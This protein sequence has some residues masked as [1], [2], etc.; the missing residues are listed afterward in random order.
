MG[1]ALQ[2]DIGHGDLGVEFEALGLGQDGAVLGDQGVAGEDDVGA[3]LVWPGPG[4][5][6]GRQAAR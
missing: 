2:I 6:I 3:G 1:E 5:E 4:V